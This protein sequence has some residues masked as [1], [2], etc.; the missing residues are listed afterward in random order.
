M[1]RQTKAPLVE[2]VCIIAAQLKLL[3]NYF[4]YKH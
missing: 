3:L 4:I 2:E 1:K